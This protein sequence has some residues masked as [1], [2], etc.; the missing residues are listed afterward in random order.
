MLARVMFPEAEPEMGLPLLVRKVLPIGLVGVVS[1]AYFS[2]IMSTADSC[3]LASVGNFINDIYQKYINPNASPR[4]VLVYSRILTVV[5]GCLSVGIAMNI[6]KVLD[7]MLLAYSF[8]VSGLFAPTLGGILWKKVSARAA[9]LSM[10]CG[11]GAAILLNVFP[12]LNPFDEA[13]LIALPFS[14]VVLVIATLLWPSV[15]RT[16]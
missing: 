16:A 1:A 14:V 9:F 5:I 11:G 8:L 7:S 3:L 6:P 12:V 15:K 10:T 13:I 2:A 4:R